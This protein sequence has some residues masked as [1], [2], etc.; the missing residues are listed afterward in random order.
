[1][2]SSELFQIALTRI[3]YQRVNWIEPACYS[4]DV[5]EID[6]G[7]M[8]MAGCKPGAGELT[9]SDLRAPANLS[10]A[11]RIAFT[12]KCIAHRPASL[13][14]RRRSAAAT[15]K[16]KG[17]PGACERLRPRRLARTSGTSPAGQRAS[18]AAARCLLR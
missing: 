5:G 17:W 8:S 15:G 7:G 12:D 10:I 4:F 16:R 3:R 13:D 18:A 2:L 9:A 6:C 14:G 1:M 11:D